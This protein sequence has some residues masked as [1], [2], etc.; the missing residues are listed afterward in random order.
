MNLF[1]YDHVLSKSTEYFHGDQLAAEVFVGKYCLQD[2]ELNYLEETPRDMHWRQAKELY[3]IEKNKFKNPYSIEFIFNLLDNFKYISMQGSP[4]YGIGNPYKFSTLS[5]C[6]VVGSPLD[7]YG[8]ILKTD[9]EIAQLSKRRGGVGTDLSNIRP[10][11]APTRNSSKF[12]TGILPYMDRYSNTIMEVGQEGRRGALMLTLAVNHPQIMDFICAKN[13]PKKVNGAN[14][15]VRLFDEFLEAVD[16]EIDYQLQWP[17]ESNKPLIKKIVKAQEIWKAIIHN[18]WLRAEPGILFWDKIVKFNAIDCYSDEG[19]KTCSTNPCCF[20]K[21]S[22]VSIVTNKGI[23]EIKEVTSDDLIWIDYKQEWKKNSGYFDAGISN[24]YKVVFSN[25]E[26]FFITE[27]HKL[28]KAKFKRNGTRV[29]YE[30]FDLVELKNLFVGDRVSIHTHEVKDYK[31]GTKGTYEEGLLLGWMTG[32][33]CLSY[34]DDKSKY[35]DMVLDFWQGEYDVA[36]K[37]HEILNG[38]GYDLLLG[39]NGTNDV[40]RIRTQI[41]TRDFIEKYETNIWK[42][43]SHDL[44]LPFLNECTLDFLKGFIS[45]YFSADGT[46]DNNR[47]TKYYQVS[48]A[49]INK[50]RLKQIKN[51]L[52]Y[53]GIRSTVS[54]LRLAGESEFKNN[55]GKY[56]AKDCWRLVI[57]GEQY[58]KRFYENFGFIANTKNKKLKEIIDIVRNKESKYHDYVS[59]KSI[60]LIGQKSVGCIEVENEHSFTA[61]GI[62]SGNSELP[63]CEKDSCRLMIQN[64]FGYVINPFEKNA[65]FDF[66]LFYQHAQIL[67]RLM[68]DVIDLEIEKIDG[69]INKIKQDPEDE[70]TKQ[71]ELALWQ[72]I[73]IKC[74]QGRRTGC[75][76]TALGDTFAALNLP[77]AQEESILLA[78]KISKTQKLGVLRGTVDMAKELGP[79]P[80][81]N[82]DKEKD[83]QFLL[84]LQQEDPQLYE[85]MSK[86]GRRNIGHLTIAP[87]GSVSILTQTTAGV[88]PLFMMNYTR[89]KKIN[90]SDENV[91]VD[92]IDDLGQK[93]KHFEVYHPKILQWM[94]ITGNKDIKKSP[95]YKCTAEEIDWTNRV[96]LQAA[97][98]LN[99]DHAISSTVNLPEDVTED[100][101][102]EIFLT[103]WKAGVKGITVY[104]KNCRTG[105]MVDNND[106]NKKDI[107]I[108]NNAPKRP[109]ELKAESHF[110]KT[111]GEEYYVVVGL[112]NN[113]PYE[114]FTGKN[115]YEDKIILPH[116]ISEKCIIRKINRGLYEL[117]DKNNDKSYV[118]NNGH[119]DDNVDALTRMISTSLRHGADISF[120]VHQLE[121]TKGDM[122]AFAKVLSRIL[123]KYIKNG[124]KVHG[125]SCPSCQSLVLER[126]DGCVTCKSCGWT[127]CN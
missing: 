1:T 13:D 21:D 93:W 105:V 83:S 27:N 121:K 99:C 91:Q 70:F 4:M 16:K 41:F 45:S 46:V 9:E 112:L 29:S 17:I 96:K 98:Q 15:S 116:D 64:L 25:N 76:I 117:V 60:E 69:I 10:N 84:P 100:K 56:R 23:K 106:I 127:K 122:S 95:W 31:F 74:E 39:S 5:N 78:S 92:F 32:D 55:G 75:G 87:T 120:V 63:L 73:R 119:S 57:S 30:G 72:D 125:E 81:W 34:H 40:K 49:S 111:K 108:K 19:F 3:R 11:K 42:F 6:Y 101:V 89:R 97:I 22:Q 20:D 37:L 82:W 85:D 28:A 51:I 67:Q 38:L 54:V 47:K 113:E 43:K 62:I 86:Y 59:I 52:L 77:Y 18:A 12:A 53:F 48:L 110:L 107:I 61:N 8:G 80:I 124:T 123:K 71:R 36:D 26:E 103:A 88:E 7:S 44:E 104:R 14:I 50:A 58:L 126:S 114:I 102:S 24:I 115:L 94:E 118:L 35:P 90:L 79:F 66:E 33:G 109:K 68:D 65:F 2:N